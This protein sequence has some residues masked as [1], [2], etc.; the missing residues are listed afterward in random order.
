M[1]DTIP[2]KIILILLFDFREL[3]HR[4]YTDVKKFAF[5]YDLGDPLAGNFALIGYDKRSD[6]T[7]AEFEQ[8]FPMYITRAIE[9]ANLPPN[10]NIK[11]NI[12]YSSNPNDFNEE[13][14]YEN[15]VDSNIYY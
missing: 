13:N 2:I 14:D 11:S 4:F 1:N 8:P 3:E 6:Q 10:P 9:E 12:R 5:K 7:F 15:M